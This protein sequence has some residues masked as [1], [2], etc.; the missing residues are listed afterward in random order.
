MKRP[1]LLPALLAGISGI[2]ILLGSTALATDVITMHTGERIE[3]KVV[4]QDEESVTISTQVARGI[5]EERRVL[6][7][8]ID[9]L[10]IKT[11]DEDAA[12]K[13]LALLPAPDLMSAEDYDRILQGQVAAFRSKFPESAML[14]RIEAAARTLSEERDKVAAGGLKFGGRWLTPEEYQA[15]KFWVDG[16]IAFRRMEAARKA[17]R[18]IEAMRHL[19][20][21]EKSHAGTRALGRALDLSKDVLLRYRS[22]V[23]EAIALQPGQEAARLRQLEGMTPGERANAEAVRQQAIETHAARVA[24]EKAAGTKWLTLDP[25]NLA[26]LNNA[27][28]TI[29]REAARLAA[30]DQGQ[31]ALQEDTLREIDTALNEGRIDAAAGLL[32]Q[33]QGTLRQL[34]YAVELDSRIKSET[35][36]QREQLAA[37]E[38]ERRA[39]EARAAREEADARLS[40]SERRQRE[41]DELFDEANSRF[42][43]AVRDS[44]IG[45]TVENAS[46]SGVAQPGDATT[47]AAPESASPEE[48]PVTATPGTGTTTTPEPTA[49]EPAAPETSTPSADQSVDESDAASDAAGSSGSGTMLLILA[50]T[51][52]LILLGL[53]LAPKFKKPEPEPTQT[54]E[55]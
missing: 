28:A 6:R 50:G 9:R 8:E 1:L 18:Y 23:D 20:S 43:R 55:E 29:D 30:I 47:G 32:A 7:D 36:R 53:I 35:A 52:L 44:R 40:E 21:L 38:E 2:C 46:D 48:Q 25:L 5:I 41:E 22:E 19:E 16:E 33:L 13:I 3:G 4:T 24:E 45:R 34:P 37:A 12:E 49:P 54:N 42:G 51:L 10:E 15:R 27:L 14:P 31:L 39:R 26:S 17:R 11:E